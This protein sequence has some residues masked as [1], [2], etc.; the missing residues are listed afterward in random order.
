MTKDKI[1]GCCGELMSPIFRYKENGYTYCTF[2]CDFCHRKQD[3]EWSADNCEEII[4]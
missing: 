3:V 1:P 4:K 2:E